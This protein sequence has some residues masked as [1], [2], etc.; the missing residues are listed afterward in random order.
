MKLT[1]RCVSAAMKGFDLP[2]LSGHPP[3]FPQVS[4]QGAALP[5]DE[6]GKCAPLR[7]DPM[8]KAESRE[9]AD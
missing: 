1:H 7:K 4:R 5:P 8:S 3:R 6:T 2:T 9:D